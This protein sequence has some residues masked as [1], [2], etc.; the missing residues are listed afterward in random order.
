MN[1]GRSSIQLHP[2]EPR[3]LFAALA[4]ADYFP[5]KPGYTWNYSGASNSAQASDSRSIHADTTSGA[6]IRIDDDT[7]VSGKSQTV[8]DY[9]DVNK[10]GVFLVRQEELADA[11]GGGL[12]VFNT[13]LHFL[14]PT[15]TVGDVLSWKNSPISATVNSAQDLITTVAGSD[16]G[17][18]TIVGLKQISL[19]NGKF[20]SALKVVL[21]H[22]ET[23]SLSNQGV[24]VDVSTHIVETTF[25]AFGIGMVESDDS[26]KQTQTAKGQT[27]S[28]T[29]SS[30]LVLDSSPLLPDFTAL[31]DGNGIL[32]V[33]GS[34]G[35][36][37]LSVI[38][39]HKQITVSNGAPSLSFNPAT[40]KGISV[41]ALD[42]N[43]VVNIAAGT[44]GAYVDAGPGNDSVV[45]G[46]GNDTL[47]GGAGKDTLYG[48]N[49]DDRLN[50]NG[51]NNFLFG[52]AGND[53]LYGGD[54]DDQLDGGG[55]VDR[56][57]A[58]A[59]ND[60]LI[61]GGGN[62]KL[63]GE[64]GNDTLY[65]GAGAD[66]IDGGAGKDKAQIDSADTRVSIATLFA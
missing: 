6:T 41:S 14:N 65:G 44:I 7:S 1:N 22:T 29:E 53:R 12:I 63:Y 13:P 23:Y 10:S 32:T 27:E 30:N 50:S 55:G 62:D 40:I 17:S 26:V 24:T 37:D 11:V 38:A 57:F 34:A 31:I 3:W 19:N 47:T 20:V 8:S 61:G 48:G 51:S 9:Y 5:A 64:D 28:A 45:G 25:L 2:L 66:I 16:S 39:A 36:D 46:D 49:G 52:Q 59:G 35:R 58:G 33:T 56:L 60:I 42:G 18:S 43:D 15:L 54:N 21:D 4:L